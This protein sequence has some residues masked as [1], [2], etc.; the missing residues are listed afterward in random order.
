MHGFAIRQP[1]AMDFRNELGNLFRKLF[2][3]GRP[4]HERLFLFAELYTEE[5]MKWR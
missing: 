1:V 2:S 3:L 5:Q 4:A